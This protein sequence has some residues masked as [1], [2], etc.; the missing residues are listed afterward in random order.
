MA[1]ILVVDD[2]PLVG[3]ALSR[4]LRREGFEVAIASDAAQ[5]LVMLDGFTP[6]LV[7][8][9]HRMPGMTGAELLALVRRR[10]PGVLRLLISGDAERA[11]SVAGDPDLEFVAKPWDGPALVA[12]LRGMLSPYD[13]FGEREVT[14]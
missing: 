11:P 10:H 6:D 8:S 13:A 7:L 5:A 3:K 2:D 1:R 14:L 12:R 4:L 9:D